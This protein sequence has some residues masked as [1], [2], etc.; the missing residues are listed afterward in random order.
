MSTTEC[1]V[2]CAVFGS[3]GL[4]FIVMLIRWVNIHF[5]VIGSSFKA[6]DYRKAG[7]D[8]PVWAIV[9]GCT[10]GIGEGFVLELIKRGFAVLMFSRS[11][12]KLKS[13][14]TSLQLANPQ[15]TIAYAAI[16]FSQKEIVPLVSKAATGKDIAV[17]VNNVGASLEFPK[18]ISDNTA[19]EIEEMIAVNVRA[20]TILSHWAVEKI[21]QRD[22]IHGKRGAILNVSSLFGSLGS[23]MLAVYSGTKSFIDS[24]SLS[25]ATELR[26]R[27]I[28]VFCCTPGYVVSNMSKL[29]RTSFTVIDGAT[30]AR[31]ALDQAGLGIVSAAPHWTHSLIRV[32]LLM[33]PEWFRC[34]KILEFHEKIHKRALSKRMR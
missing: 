19:A 34:A 14:S 18:D 29:K 1:G 4:V 7:T 11:A 24:F 5:L 16:D 26:R 3:L 15:A 9:T 28:S 21:S 12:E 20:T 17:L 33:L 22:P 32:G 23:P 6:S 30:C 10:S 25:I 8:G 31:N 2:S 13:L 27:G